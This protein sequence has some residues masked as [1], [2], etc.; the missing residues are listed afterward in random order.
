PC[1]LII[2]VDSSSLATPV[3]GY[4][5]E[6]V[7]HNG[8]LIV[9]AGTEV[10]SFAKRGRV[11]DRIEVHGEW[12]FVWQDGK[13]VQVNGIALDRQFDP[14]SDTYGITDGSAG[15]RGKLEKTDEFLEFKLFTATAIS[16]A[17][18]RSE[19][20]TRT[21]FGSEPSNSLE[22]AGLEGAAAVTDRYANLLMD[23]I[24]DDGLFVRVPAGT[25][26]YVYTLQVFEP[27]L[28]S[29]AGLVQGHRARNSWEKARQKEGSDSND[30]ASDP[31][32]RTAE[33][34]LERREQ[35]AALVRA[36]EERRRAEEAGTGK[37]PNP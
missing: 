8:N 10:H 26:F 22:N 19:D 30:P 7:W 15:I 31:S 2:T 34:A 6:D 14:N 33:A 18:R 28:A 12:K 21:I 20:T 24:E 4:V 16:G 1:Q 37:N 27:K 35:L 23:Q 13:E 36:R 32:L 3:V 29:V 17:A 11:R 25:Q 9:P 5:S